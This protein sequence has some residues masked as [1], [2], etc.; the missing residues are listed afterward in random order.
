MLI[1]V[2]VTG[3]EWLEGCED[4]EDHDHPAD[5]EAVVDVPDSVRDD[6]LA[7]NDAIHEALRDQC[8][9]CIIDATFDMTEIEEVNI[10]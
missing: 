5:F 7:L 3:A 8:N 4:T 1:H 9:C 2:A 10:R 6:E